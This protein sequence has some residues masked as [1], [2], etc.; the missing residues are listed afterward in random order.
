METAD[1]LTGSDAWPKVEREDLTDFLAELAEAA[2]L[3]A[4]RFVVARFGGLTVSVP[5][6]HRPGRLPLWLAEVAE[7]CGPGLVDTIIA[8]RAGEM[9]AIPAPAT[10]HEA[11]VRREI[12][13]LYD[14]RNGGDLAVR[15][16][17]SRRFVQKVALG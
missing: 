1:M 2:G 3:D 11:V 16:Q 6:R 4:V 13:R 8:L 12:R 5:M 17:C 7:H 9:F 14:G 10:L 15:F